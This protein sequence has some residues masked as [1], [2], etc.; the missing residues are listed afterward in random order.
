M[1][2]KHKAKR[3]G[4]SQAKGDSGAKVNETKEGKKQPQG[5]EPAP[6]PTAKPGA[7][8]TS[9]VRLKDVLSS[10]TPEQK[11]ETCDWFGAVSCPDD[12]TVKITPEQK[13]HLARY[14]AEQWS[15]YDAKSK[16]FRKA[17]PM[18]EE[19]YGDAIDTLHDFMEQEEWFAK[20]TPHPFLVGHFSYIPQL[21]SLACEYL[22]KLARY[23]CENAIRQLAGLTVEMTETMTDLLSGESEE[24]KRRAEIMQYEAAEL[25]YWP[26]LHFRNAT[27]NNHFSRVADQLQLGKECPINVSDSAKFSLQTPINGFVWKCLRHFQKVHQSIRYHMESSA[28]YTPEKPKTFEEAIKWVVFQKVE[29]PPARKPYIAGMIHW[30]EIPIYKA[31][32]ALEPLTKATAKKWADVAIVPFVCFRHRDFSDVSAFN[33]T[34]KRDGVRTRG[35]QRR[36]IRKDIIRALTALAREA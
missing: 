26:M 30:E 33:D 2:R 10:L 9:Y 31:S 7:S 16:E 20:N 12:L 18:P 23:G 13:A 4:H 22:Q 28:R 29:A 21:A 34:L 17:D 32:Y 15:E 1:K 14:W 27:A 5:G 8:H 6:A 36:E 25:P 35:Q 3:K 19:R 11:Q 24:T